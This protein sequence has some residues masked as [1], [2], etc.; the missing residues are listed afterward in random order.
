MKK[1]VNKILQRRIF[2]GTIFRSVLYRVLKDT[3][4]TEDIKIV[5]RSGRKHCHAGKSRNCREADE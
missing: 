2:L 1:T 3:D 4:E 5:I